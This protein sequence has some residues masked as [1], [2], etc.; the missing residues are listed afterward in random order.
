MISAGRRNSTPVNSTN[1]A[2][3]RLPSD[4]GGEAL[5]QRGG[6]DQGGKGNTLLHGVATPQP[7]DNK[8]AWLPDRLRGNWGEL[9][10]LS[11]GEGRSFPASSTQLSVG[12]FSFPFFR[13]VEEASPVPS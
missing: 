1:R 11:R 8:W 3:R 4:T 10:R 6:P 7:L 13:G 9:P 12:P 5:F 2:K